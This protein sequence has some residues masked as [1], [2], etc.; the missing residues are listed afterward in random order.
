MVALP[1]ADGSGLRP[2]QW[3]VSRT[4]CSSGSGPKSSTVGV[5]AKAQAG[6]AGRVGQGATRP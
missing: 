1:L 6:F 3:S 2:G 4:A 5:T